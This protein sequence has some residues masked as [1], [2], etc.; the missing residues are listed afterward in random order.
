MKKAGRIRRA[1]TVSITRPRGGEN[2][3]EI[4]RITARTSDDRLLAAYIEIPLAGFAAALM[5]QGEVECVIETKPP[6]E[7]TQ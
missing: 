5:G 7:P 1:G 2:D 3:G 6:Q 4:V